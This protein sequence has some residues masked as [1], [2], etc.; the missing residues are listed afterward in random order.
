MIWRTLWELY[1][2]T[3]NQALLLL[4]HLPSMKY[5]MPVYYV[6]CFCFSW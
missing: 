5:S 2:Q 4:R 3:G 6:D 1:S